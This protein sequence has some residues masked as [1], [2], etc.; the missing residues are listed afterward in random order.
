MLDRTLFVVLDTLFTLDHLAVCVAV[1]VEVRLVEIVCR[2]SAIDALYHPLDLVETVRNFVEFL[3]GVATVVLLGLFGLF[4]QF[5]AP[6]HISGRTKIQQA[7]SASAVSP[8]IAA[9]GG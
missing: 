1:P 6:L 7:A 9:G 4:A 8:L 3:V 2:E 5:A